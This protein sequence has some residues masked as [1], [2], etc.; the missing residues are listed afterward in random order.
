MISAFKYLAGKRYFP[1]YSLFLILPVLF[2][3]T[4]LAYYSQSI[5]GH[6]DMISQR[7]LVTDVV[8]DPETS[9]E[10][11]RRLQVSSEILAFAAD[12]MHLDAAGSYRHYADIGRD[13]VVWNVVAT[14]KLSLT[15]ETWCFPFAGCV[16]Y[17]GY[18]DKG[19]AESFADKLSTEQGLDT[20]VYGVTAYS[21][22]GWFDDPLLNTFLF[23]HEIRLVELLLHELAHQK[24]YLEDDSELNEAFAVVVAQ[25]GAELWLEEHAEGSSLH[26]L[27]QIRSREGQFFE[28]FDTIRSE[29]L[30]LY[31]S[32]LSDKEK[33]TKKKTVLVHFR[34]QYKALHESWQLKPQ[35][36]WLEGELNNA[37]FAAV[38]TYRRLV[39]PLERIWETVGGRPSDFYELVNGL[40]TLDKPT[41]RQRLLEGKVSSSQE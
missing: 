20:H 27:R 8:N 22:L 15:P 37:R 23:E 13:Y 21:T 18:Y 1:R 7:R 40:A 36:G 39:P 10:V 35:G 9:A 3:C 32:E 2:S 19:D 12:T 24:F 25:K 4:E 31:A 11:K 33:L 34:Q 26:D 17:R 29:L 38:A 41:R 16:P 5:K 6:L 14:P 30:D 28:L